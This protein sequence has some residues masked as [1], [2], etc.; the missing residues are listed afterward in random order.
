VNAL[1]LTVAQS[2]GVSLCLLPFVGVHGVASLFT[3]PTMLWR[4]GYLMLAGT[5]LAPLFQVESQR[6]LPTGRV[7]LLFALEPVFA[8]LFAV[9]FGGERFLAR[10]WIGAALILCA[11]LVAEWRS[12]P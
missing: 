10:W 9:W 7:A 3:R 12:A 5:V 2:L 1:A 8:L 4:V 6:T 11:V